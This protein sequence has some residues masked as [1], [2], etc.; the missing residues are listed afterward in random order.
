MMDQRKRVKINKKACVFWIGLR[1]LISSQEEEE[2]TSIYKQRLFQTKK[3]R[4]FTLFPFLDF[5]CN[6]KKGN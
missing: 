4:K 5:R 2:V 6:K 3:K 1:S